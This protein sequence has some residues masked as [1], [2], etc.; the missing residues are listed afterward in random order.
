MKRQQQPNGGWNDKKVLK[1]RTFQAE[2]TA[3]AN[4]QES[5]HEL[6]VFGEL[7]EVSVAGWRRQRYEAGSWCRAL[8]AA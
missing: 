8:K 3:G 2:G 7:K 1:M 6:G 4:A 5:R